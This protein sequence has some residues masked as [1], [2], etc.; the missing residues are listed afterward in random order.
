MLT[1]AQDQSSDGVTGFNALERHFKLNVEQYID[2]SHAVNN[3]WNLAVAAV[4]GKSMMVLNAVSWNVPHGPRK[5]EDLRLHQCRDCMEALYKNK[6]PETTPLFQ[7]HLGRICES[8]AAMGV[9]L[10]GIE[11]V[12]KEVW[13]YLRSRSILGRAGR[14][15]NLSRFCAGPCH[16]VSANKTWSIDEFERTFCCLEMDF[17][18]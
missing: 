10:P 2:Q 1:I 6:L 7:I 9:K 12:E 5:G 13:A 16:L 8:L 4:G 15:V 11:S 18:G 14:R 17:F 3:D